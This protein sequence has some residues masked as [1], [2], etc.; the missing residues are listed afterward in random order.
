MVK[1]RLAMLVDIKRCIG[2]HT[3]A[4]ACKLNN[5]LPN[6]IWWNRVLT[7][8]G[9]SM[10]TPK[11]TYPNLK[12]Q[13]LT[14]ACQHCEK[15]ACVKACPTGAAHQRE[16]GIVMQDYEKCVGCRL[17]VISC[18]Y[19]N[20]RQFNETEP[21]YFPDYP[22]GDYG[23]IDQEKG[24]VSKCNFCYQRVDRGE[25]PSCIEVCPAKAR[26]FGD[27]TDPNSDVSQRLNGR[28]YTQLLSEKGTQPSVYFLL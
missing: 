28:Q 14:L 9:K 8:G 6:E 10:D 21:A 7:Y 18:P 20:V 5:N 11:G 26:F 27:L 22:T 15:P 3:C 2:C 17:C 1:K 12:L 16:D 4:V 19:Q 25:A 23:I 13:Y 24:T